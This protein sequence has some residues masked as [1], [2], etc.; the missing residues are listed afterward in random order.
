MNL[1]SGQEVWGGVHHYGSEGL[2]QPYAS[3]ARIIVSGT[4]DLEGVKRS[5]APSIRFVRFLSMVRS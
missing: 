3:S 1:G 2:P 4:A 5:P